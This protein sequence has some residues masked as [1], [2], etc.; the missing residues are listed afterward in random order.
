[1]LVYC[2]YIVRVLCRGQLAMPLL[3]NRNKNIKTVHSPKSKIEMT[4]P[5][6]KSISDLDP[7]S[8]SH[9]LPR[10]FGLEL[11]LPRPSTRPTDPL[12]GVLGQ[13]RRTPYKYKYN[14]LAQYTLVVSTIW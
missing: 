13:V 9:P 12:Y 11:K 2:A 8:P 3:T 4:N 14:V 5:T 7:I 10:Y 1:M 6:A